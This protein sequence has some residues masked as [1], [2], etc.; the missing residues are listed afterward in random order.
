MLGFVPITDIIGQLQI[1][2][3]SQPS[4]DLSGQAMATYTRRWE[5]NPARIEIYI[6]N[7]FKHIKDAERF[8]LMRPIQEYG[9]A[10]ALYH[11]IGHHVGATKTH[12]VGARKSETHAERYAKTIMNRY[13][14]ANAQIIEDCFKL[15]GDIANVRNISLEVINAMKAGWTSRYEKASTSDKV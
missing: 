3:T 10:S 13:I 14:L 15:L 1:I 8:E 4:S 6:T 9:L 12:G 2:V 5:R 11:E 7:L